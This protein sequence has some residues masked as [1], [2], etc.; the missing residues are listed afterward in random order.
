MLDLYTHADAQEAAHQA[1]VRAAIAVDAAISAW[2]DQQ[3]ADIGADLQDK[4]RAYSHARWVYATVC[5]ELDR[6]RSALKVAEATSTDPLNDPAVNAAQEAVG[7]AEDAYDET[8]QA[9]ISAHAD[10]GT[11]WP[12][13]IV[14]IQDALDAAGDAYTAV[15]RANLTGARLTGAIMPDGTT[16]D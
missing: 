2:L 16:H 5:F 3:S 11:T 9:F 4:R 8:R 14:A 10:F 6:K 13:H 12:S 15:W 1:V 7:A